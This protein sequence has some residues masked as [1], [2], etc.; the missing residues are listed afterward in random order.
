MLAQDSETN[1]INSSLRSLFTSDV[2]GM[3]AGLNR[4]D[5]LGFSSNGNDDALATTEL[6]NLDDLLATNLNGLK[7]LFTKTDAGLAARV[8]SYLENVV[9]DDGSLIKHQDSLTEQSTNLDKQIEDQ[10]RWV[11]ANRQRMVDSFVA[12]ETA[13]AK[14]NQQLQYLSQNFS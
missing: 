14:I 8:N 11:Q 13:Q 5:D 7:T 3:A 2:S 6:S 10:E 12:M 4:L 1:D 9:G